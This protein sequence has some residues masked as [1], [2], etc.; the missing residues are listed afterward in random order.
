[1]LVLS[2]TNF[3]K[4]SVKYLRNTSVL[5]QPVSE[6]VPVAPGDAPFN[7]ST[8]IILPGKIKY[9]GIAIP[10]ALPAPM[11]VTVFHFPEVTA[12]AQ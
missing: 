5:D 9:G 6:T 10:L 12:C 11:M 8:F 2:G 7:K 4:C 1:L 3:R